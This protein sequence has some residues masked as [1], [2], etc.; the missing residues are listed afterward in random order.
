MLIKD[1][2]NPQFSDFTVADLRRLISAYATS[3]NIYKA[4]RLKKDAL[5]SELNARFS[6]DPDGTVRHRAV[7]EHGTPFADAVSSISHGSLR[8]ANTYAE[9]GFKRRKRNAWNDGEGNQM[10]VAPDVFKAPN[11]RRNVGNYDQPGDFNNVNYNP[12]VDYR[13][14]DSNQAEQNDYDNLKKLD[15]GVFDPDANGLYE[16]LYNDGFFGN[17]SAEEMKEVIDALP[18]TSPN[19][20][21]VQ[22]LADNNKG[23]AKVSDIGQET[24]DRLERERKIVDGTAVGL[25]YPAQVAQA[26]VKVL[27]SAFGKANQKESTYQALPRAVKND[28]NLSQANA[29]KAAVVSL[30]VISNNISNSTSLNTDPVFVIDADDALDTEDEYLTV[31]SNNE[32]EIAKYVRELK[33][34]KYDRLALPRAGSL[35]NRYLRLP[36]ENASDQIKLYTSPFGIGHFPET[37]LWRVVNPNEWMDDMGTAAA[38]VLL[39]ERDELYNGLENRN[40]PRVK[41]LHHGC[42]FIGG[43]HPSSA[44]PKNALPMT[45]SRFKEQ[46]MDK[47]CPRLKKGRPIEEGFEYKKKN[48]SV[49]RLVLPTT[50]PFVFFFM[51]KGLYHWVLYCIDLFQKRVIVVDSTHKESSSGSSAS[52]VDVKYCQK[53]FNDL[54]SLHSKWYLGRLEKQVSPTAR[55]NDLKDH[56]RET[57]FFREWLKTPWAQPKDSLIFDQGTN[58]THCGTFA[59]LAAEY[60]TRN[61]GVLKQSRAVNAITETKYQEEIDKLFLTKS[62]LYTNNDLPYERVRLAEAILRGKLADYSDKTITADI[63]EW[64]EY[65]PRHYE[66]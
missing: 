4:H 57:V 36:M 12:N 65:D 56:A 16:D 33:V 18:P 38:C 31:P 54:V 15:L 11:N 7:T 8:A 28:V 49:S 30:A 59:F 37:S 19:T 53:F 50:T 26:P 47:F 58:G 52:E 60:L 64:G 32:K 55:E 51:N 5:S 40:R 21:A 63:S 27:A 48:Y 14:E 42:V 25:A 24:A 17:Q 6:I 44:V 46:L 23:L 61:L 35:Q 43:T 45:E 66:G 29:A 62:D 34:S 3:F 41:G 20:S 13:V 9:P 22:R 1:P 39:N 10:N 2:N